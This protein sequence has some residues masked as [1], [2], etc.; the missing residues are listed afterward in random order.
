MKVY[1]DEGAFPPTRAHST[2]AGLDLYCRE[3]TYVPAH[4]SAV[5]DTGVHIQLPENTYGSLQSKS[6]LNVNHGIVSCGGT[7]DQSYSGP[8]KVKLYNMT[9]KDYFFKRG[10]KICQLVV[11]PCL[12]VPVEIVPEWSNDTERGDNGFGSTGV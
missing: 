8:I 1:L 6:G 7:I 2:D 12:F 4:G 10:S 3:S 9:D 5:F 11:E